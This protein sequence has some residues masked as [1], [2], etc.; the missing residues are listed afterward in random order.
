MVTFNS[1]HTEQ[2]MKEVAQAFRK[3]LGAYAV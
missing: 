3:V 1:F 2:D